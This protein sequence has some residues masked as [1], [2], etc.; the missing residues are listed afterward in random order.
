MIPSPE[1]SRV[2][3][4]VLRANVVCRACAGAGK[5]T[6]M[7][8]AVEAHPSKHF[9]VIAYNSRLKDETRSKSSHLD[10]VEVHTFHSFAVKYISSSS[11]TDEGLYEALEARTHGAL[12]EYDV[13]IVDEAQ[14]CTDLYRRVVELIPRGSLAL[15]G[16]ERQLLYDFKGAE[17]RFLTE[18]PD[19]FASNGKPWLQLQL[20]QTFRMTPEI[21]R[22][23]NRT[24]LKEDLIRSE[25][26]HGSRVQYGFY[27]LFS[28][29]HILARALDN[30]CRKI[31]PQNVFVLA[32]SL[33]SPKCPAKQIA[34]SLHR[35]NP[36]LPIFMADDDEDPL[37]E[38]VVAGKLVFATFHSTKGLERL[39]VFVLGF[40]AYF[41]KMFEDSDPGMCPPPLY[42][43]ATRA[44]R[45]LMLINSEEEP[46]LPFLDFAE[47]TR[48]SDVHGFFKGNGMNPASDDF[49][50][51]INVTACTRFMPPETL[52]AIKRR[53]NVVVSDPD[54]E[55]LEFPSHVRQGKL[56]EQ[57]SDIIGLAV[58]Y[59]HER[60]ETCAANLLPDA[61]RDITSSKNTHFRTTQMRSFDWLPDSFFE[62]TNRRISR[63]VDQGDL[64]Y[65]TALEAP[66]DEKRVLVGRSDIFSPGANMVVEVKCK[67]AVDTSN[68]IQAFVYGYMHSLETKEFP[69][70]VLVNVRDGVS[71]S[72]FPN[73]PDEVFRMIFSS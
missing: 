20:T 8:M 72:L 6:T 18:A 44:K 32:S 36:R 58:N 46:P 48:E 61:L 22:F 51:R 57:T 29:R 56:Y 39:A 25:V 7:L 37:D 35:L 42:V 23:V 63:V 17:S 21:S 10:N 3:S 73:N 19:I 70:C 28:E 30:A 55:P 11:Y 15:F 31:G 71:Y 34:E 50:R 41:Y 49:I 69:R 38:K 2:V 64:V 68:L 1:Q 13:V 47:V 67:A 14:D 9:L 45:C 66:L 5:S 40:D 53:L 52:V 59:A 16:D 43:A 33:R 27:N 24:M 12:P 26:S 65:E 62:E 4:A 60:G 54:M